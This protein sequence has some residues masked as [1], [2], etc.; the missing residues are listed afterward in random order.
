[1]P[2]QSETYL[3]KGRV[4]IGLA[5]GSNATS[6]R[7][8]VGQVQV[9]YTTEKKTQPNFTQGGGGNYAS[10]ESVSGIALA[11]KLFDHTAE[12]MAFAQLG[13][14]T[15]ISAGAVLDE[16]HN[17]RHDGLMMFDN[18]PDTTVP[19][20][21]T[22]TGGAITY[23][24]GTDYL[25]NSAG[26][27]II[28]T[29]DGGSIVEAAET[30]VDYTKLAS[31]VVQALTKSAQE[32]KLQMVGLNE[33]RS[34]KAVNLDIYKAKFGPAAS[35]EY[36]GVDFGEMDLVAEILADTSKVASETTSQ[37]YQTKMAA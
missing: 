1:M 2:F 15:A 35:F 27:E 29:A 8:N 7:G 20:I 6:Y 36:L 14:A 13:A 34:G 19:Y 23:V 10:I 5:D 25:E 12:N 16:S 32:Y 31:N 33:A 18:M 24:L 21:V 9:A 4:F 17:A 11:I 30:L 22:N 3:G 28:N 26:I 37:Y